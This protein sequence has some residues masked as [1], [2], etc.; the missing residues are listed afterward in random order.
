MILKTRQF[1]NRIGEVGAGQEA[2]E[3]MGVPF[4]SNT[5]IL[6]PILSLSSFMILLMPVRHG[7]EE[8]GKVV[9]RYVSGPVL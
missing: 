9:L 7:R 5:M 8:A 1:R 2:R 4:S 6:F 3:H